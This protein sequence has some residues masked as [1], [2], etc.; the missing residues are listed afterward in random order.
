[1][2][3][4]YLNDKRVF[5]D[6]SQKIKITKENPYFTNSG[7]Y[8]LDVCIPM[9]VLE[10]RMFFNNIQCLITSKK[11]E[12]LKALLVVDNNILLSGTAVINSISDRQIKV[13][14]LGGNSDV[15]FI[16]NYGDVY[17]DEIDYGEI[18][19][20]DGKGYTFQGERGGVTVKGYTYIYGSWPA[21][22][23]PAMGEVSD[24]VLMPVYDETNEEI[25]NKT[26]VHV[27]TYEGSDIDKDRPGVYTRGNAI[28]PN[29]MMVIKKVINNFGYELVKNDVDATPWNRLV[30]CNARNTL[31]VN[32]ALPHWK[33]T[34][35]LKEVQNFFN[36]TFIFNET[37]KTAEL[38][39][40]INYFDKGVQLYEP[41]DTYSSDVADEDEETRNRWAPRI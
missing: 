25:K 30:I 10:N 5:T 23:K 14:L 12:K 28:M 9:D 36:C 21:Y 4:L 19:V 6:T 37:E 22:E 38:I 33:V 13:Q 26:D 7:S 32:E 34:D 39:S 35:F 3:E 40:N 17:I 24:Y 8:T 1:M 11:T 20:Y 27:G 41:V 29:L 18:K 2:I 31:I 16:A 15:N